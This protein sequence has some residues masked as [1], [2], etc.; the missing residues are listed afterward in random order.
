[1]RSY[2]QGQVHAILKRPHM[3]KEYAHLLAPWHYQRH[4]RSKQK[5]QMN[6][7]NSETNWDK[8]PSHWILPFPP[9]LLFPPCVT[10]PA[11]NGRKLEDSEGI[12]SQTIMHYDQMC[13]EED[14][15]KIT[16]NPT[17]KSNRHSSDAYTSFNLHRIENDLWNFFH[18]NVVL[19][20]GC[21]HDS[22]ETSIWISNPTPNM[23]N[24]ER[25][26]CWASQKWH[27]SQG[28]LNFKTLRKGLANHRSRLALTSTISFKKPPFFGWGVSK[29]KNFMLLNFTKY[30][31]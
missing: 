2:G 22:H 8:I 26:T 1:M 28:W 5:P 23:G 30:Q 4:D 25:S 3:P 19:K 31:N 9:I 29:Q 12:L 20:I 11:K 15:H 14:C 18:K 6:N 13:Y 7:G 21:I 24:P 16:Q 10:H 17:S 27:D